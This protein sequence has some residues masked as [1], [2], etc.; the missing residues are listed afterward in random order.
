VYGE[1]WGATSWVSISS[2]GDPQSAVVSLRDSLTRFVL[3]L[4]LQ[5]VPG[6]SSRRAAEPAT[7]AQTDTGTQ[8]R[9]TPQAVGPGVADP[10]GSVAGLRSRD[11][12]NRA[13]GGATVTVTGL[14]PQLADVP[15]GD[16]LGPEFLD[17]QQDP[18]VHLGSPQPRAVPPSLAGSGSWS[19]RMVAAVVTGVGVAALAVALLVTL[20]RRLLRFRHSPDGPPASL[21]V[22]N[23]GGAAPLRPPGLQRQ[24]SVDAEAL[25]AG[26]TPRLHLGGQLVR[27]RSGGDQALAKAKAVA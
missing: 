17:H 16:G 11:G 13:A 21:S 15:I 24:V 14:E 12:D 23:A 27:Q 3:R 8:A 4:T 18:G 7:V 1:G 25:P 20:G 6:P 5:P 9:V 10:D 19:V 26:G 2:D 22:S